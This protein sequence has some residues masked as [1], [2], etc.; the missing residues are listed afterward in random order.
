[1]KT[2]FMQELEQ[3]YSELSKRQDALNRYYEVLDKENETD[4]NDVQELLNTFFIHLN[5]EQ[6][7]EAQMAAL[8]RM[9]SL[10]EDALEQVLEK[11][12]FTQEEIITKKE[13]AYR[14]VS[15]MHL[16]RHE[17]LIAYIETQGLLTPFYRALISGIH[18]VGVRLTEWQSEW[19]QHIIYGV[20][21][22]LKEHYSD[23]AKVMAFLEENELL[24][25]DRQGEVADRCYSALVKNQHGNYQS[26]AYIDAFPNATKAVILAL[27]EL[28]E[29]LSM[30]EDEVFHQKQEW[31]LYFNTLKSAFKES[32]TKQLIERWAEVDRVWMQIKTPLQIGHPLEYYEDH[33]RKAVALEWDLRIVNP[34]LQEGSDTKESIKQFAY[35]MAEG[36]GEKA[37]QV[38][39]NNLT[40]VDRTQLYIGQPVLYY[41]AEFNG[42]FS[43][44]VV[45]NDEQVSSELGKKIFA[46][47]DFVLESKKAKPIMRLSVESMGKAFIQKQRSVMEEHPALWHKIYDISTIGHEYGHILWIDAHTESVMNKS[48]QF[49]NIEEFK[50]TT[51]G[52]MAFFD[53]DKSEEKS[54][55][56]EHII[57]DVVSRAV[58]LMAWREV[59]EVL[60][61]Y[62]EGLIHLALL[63]SSGVMRYENEVVIDYSRYEVMK[64]YYQKAYQNLAQ[65]YLAKKD[66]FEYLQQY[67]TLEGEHY[68]PA[69]I[70]V[71][72]F[73][74]YYYKRY[75]EIGQETMTLS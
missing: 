51:G 40:Q 52:L 3:I 71:K 14:F 68:L 21:R 72:A 9:V 10:R 37:V 57:N 64:E 46:Y 7:K 2:K 38:I 8:T 31:L 60:P 4:H 63:F 24:D 66:A 42:L 47:A 70:T 73:V 18:H 39:E 11:Q 58:G 12:G 56:K 43:A 59:G 26:V 65:H 44:Q 33:Y 6:T 41:A 61:Y 28:V 54:P 19:T 36:F 15:T 22:E 1:M 29:K 30:F 49:K 48:G 16:K 45:P 20:N 27:E 32:D 13:L 62:C 74:E 25:K 17:E 53:A 35:K 67:V 55:L 34:T 50:A 23:D 75:K 69:N 5:I